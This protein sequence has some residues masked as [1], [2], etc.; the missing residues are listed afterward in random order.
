MA[1]SFDG[2]G[3][4]D[5]DGDT[6]TYAWDFG[7]RTTGS[8][9]TPSHTYDMAGNYDVR[10][11]VSDGEF[12]SPAAV[13]VVDIADRAAPGSGDSLYVAYCIGCHGDP[14]NGPAVDDALAGK[15]RVAGARS[16]N[17]E[18]SIFG[19]SVFPDGAPGMQFLQTLSDDEIQSLA[20]YLN[21]EPTIGE[22]R[23]VST[24]AGCHG[25][26]GEGGRVG[27]GVRGDSAHETWEAI[28]EES[29]MR[30]LACMPEDD[31]VVI[32]DY[33]AGQGDDDERE[34]FDI[35]THSG[36]GAPGVPT[37]LLLLV[38]GLA[39]RAYRQIA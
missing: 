38:V 28:R 5:P 15:R 1:V 13:T 18:G 7:D 20:G 3:S 17:I 24:C 9:A 33:L 10:L 22:R 34:S 31:I 8:G 23:Y 30:Y 39:R 32:A 2:T 14:W 37:L 27:E 11:V 25:D 19:T 26:T 4:S 29:E 36:G 6:L 35:E 16:C 12:E 21:S